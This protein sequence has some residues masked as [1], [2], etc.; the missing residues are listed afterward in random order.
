MEEKSLQ[1]YK[2][3]LENTKNSKLPFEWKITEIYSSTW[4]NEVHYSSFR[5]NI[6]L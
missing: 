2:V 1:A 4:E 6:S 3:L 5:L